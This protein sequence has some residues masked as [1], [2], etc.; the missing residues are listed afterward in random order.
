MAENAKDKTNTRKAWEAEFSALPLDEKLA[1]LLRMEA[2]TLGE[3]LTYIANSS[4]NVMEKAG[5][6]IN[7]V[8]TK[9]EIGI[10]RA[11]KSADHCGFE[12][13]GAAKEAK[14][15]SGGGKRASK[16][17]HENNTPPPSPGI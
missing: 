7:E 2:A 6:F 9:I 15:K 10:K 13:T 1:S 14:Q 12:D 5:E 17:P 3:T 11:A 4:A 8:G 16:K